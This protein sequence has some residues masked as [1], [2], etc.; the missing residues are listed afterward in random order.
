MKHK[1]I[2]L[3]AE[4]VK[5][6]GFF[7]GYGSVFGVKDSYGDIVR[8]GAFTASIGEW[9][10]KG[11]MPK[12]L[13]QHDPSQPIGVWE[14][15]EEDGHG[16]KMQGRLL[17]DDVAKAREA[18]ALMK[19]GAI[20]GLSIGYSVKRAK[21]NEDEDALDLFALNLWET[22]IVTFPANEAATVSEVKTAL[23][24][25][26]LPTLKA[27]E[28]FLREAG[29]SNSQ[30]TAIAGHGLRKLHQGE[31]DNADITAALSILKGI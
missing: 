28:K 9:K 11:K 20:D 8:P 30:A 16:L 21:W 10:A 15:I 27:F 14:S 22:S 13:W 24:R 26:E 7:I 18:Y 2:E 23:A 17:I 29:F 1:S 25:G 19:S 6:D 31:P 3:K 12:L 4:A 5:E